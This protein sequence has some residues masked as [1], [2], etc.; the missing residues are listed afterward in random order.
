MYTIFYAK[1]LHE[2]V[3]AS[4]IHDIIKKLEQLNNYSI[5]SNAF[6]VKALLLPRFIASVRPSAANV[7]PVPRVVAQ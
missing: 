5:I 3:F 7:K 1:T 4:A 6:R 2:N